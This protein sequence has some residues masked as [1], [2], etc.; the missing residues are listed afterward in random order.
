[1]KAMIPRQQ[2]VLAVS[3]VI[4]CRYQQSVYRRSSSKQRPGRVFP[5]ST[6]ADCV[7]G[8]PSFG[9]PD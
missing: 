2:Q 4:A 6:N 1:M 8:R 5:T 9:R 3:D 7:Q